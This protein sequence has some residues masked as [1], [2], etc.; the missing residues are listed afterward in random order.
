MLRK[1][2]SYLERC[3]SKHEHRNHS[4]SSMCVNNVR[5]HRSG[6][7]I[8]STGRRKKGWFS[9]WKKRTHTYKSYFVQLTS[10]SKKLQVKPNV[11]CLKNVGQHGN[12]QS[13]IH[14]HVVERREKEQEHSPYD[15]CSDQIHF[16]FWTVR[17]CFDKLVFM[18]IY[19]KL[20][21]IHQT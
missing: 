1:S 10:S 6:N 20:R 4:V 18:S 14:R 19:N 12:R 9:W 2:I 7:K 11:V 15:M 21:A 5:Q 13:H 3:T 16:G 17:G 8:R